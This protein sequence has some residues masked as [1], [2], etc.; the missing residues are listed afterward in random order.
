MRFALTPE[1]EDFAGSLDKL[2]AASDTVAVARAWAEGDAVPGLELWQRLAEQGLTMLA[3][4][5]TPVE[6]TVA[7][8]ALG[9]F[10]VPGPWVESAVYL[11][12][13]LGHEIECI[14]T[15]AAPLAVDADVADRVYALGDDAV[16]RGTVGERRTSIDPTRRLFT[17]T[18]G[19]AVA[20]E[21]L[22]AAWNA[23]VLAVSA[24]LLGLGEHLLEESVAY[25]KQRR[26]FGREIGSYQAIK[27]ALADVRIALDF[28]RPM[29]H[30]AALGA[31]P[32]SA[33]KVMAGD[34]AYLASRTALQVH[35]AIGYTREL[36]LSLWMLKTRALVTAWGTPAQHRVRVLEAL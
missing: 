19:E 2:L 10:A 9:R 23:A 18:P 15:V 5:A 6:V 3:T 27:H 4:E 33:A 22:D 17:V 28:A 1:Q 35:G 31:M 14:G 8:E 26:Q 24:Q 13:L 21:N 12:V 32:A 34:A 20:S 25:V 16:R 36:D 29:V 7:F 30:G 11:P